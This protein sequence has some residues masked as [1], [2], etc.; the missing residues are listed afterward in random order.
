MAKA[1]YNHEVT[2]ASIMN[3]F[4]SFFMLSALVSKEEL[5]QARE[6]ISGAESIGFMIDPTKY[7]NAL[8]SGSLDQQRKLI[9]LFYETRKKL[10]EI[11][12]KDASLLDR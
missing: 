2:M 4:R 8:Y 12:P 9:D 1:P 11:F 10:S 6:A 3:A 7:R 5:E